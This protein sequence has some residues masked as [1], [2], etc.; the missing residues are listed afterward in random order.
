MN[1]TNL[2]FRAELKR[3]STSRLVDGMSRLVCMSGCASRWFAGWGPK[4]GVETRALYD[5]CTAGVR[6]GEAVFV[7]REVEL[8]E[9]AAVLRAAPGVVRRRWWCAVRRVLA[10][11]RFAARSLAR[12]RADRWRVVSVAARNAGEPYGALAAMLEQILV[13]GTGV[14]EALPPRSRSIV[15]Q[16]TPLA[17]TSAALRGR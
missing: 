2:G 11:R 14:L 1:G 15:A 7:G 9:A 12:A 13:E 6:V 4:P 16:L 5:R 8:A 17:G 3:R 10:N